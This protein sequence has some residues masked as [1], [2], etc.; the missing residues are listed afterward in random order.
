MGF[1]K[2]SLVGGFGLAL[3]S[4]GGGEGE[5]CLLVQDAEEHHHEEFVR[6][7]LGRTS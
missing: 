4:H 6:K 2:N 3:P 7:G 5:K 1:G